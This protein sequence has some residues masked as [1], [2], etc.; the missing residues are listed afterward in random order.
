MEHS[1][2][3][4][5][6]ISKIKKYHPTNNFAQVEKAYKIALEAHGDQLR[7]SGEPYIIHPLS[8]AV[9]LA[10]LE[11]D[12]ESIIAGILH[13]VIEDTVFSFEDISNM[14]SEEIA[15]IVDGVT[16][17]DKIQYKSAEDLKDGT[18]DT[19]KL[20][21]K[22]ERYNQEVLAE[23]YRK[24]FLAMAKDIRVILIK[25][26]DRLH[27]MRTLKFMKPEKQKE[28]AQE[29]LDIYAPLAHRLGIS[30]IRYELEDLSFRYLYPDAYYDL[31]DK[32]K[33]KQSERLEYVNKI[34]DSVKQKLN[35]SG[36]EGAVEGRPK[37][38]FSIYK[39][40]VSQNKTLDQIYDLFAVRVIV[41]SI[42]DCYTVL[43]IVHEVYTPMPGRFKDYIAMPKSNVYQSLHTSLVGS[44]GEPFEVQIRT[45]EMHRRAE[46]GIAAH[47]R[48]KE[49]KSKND[50]G[51]KGG[52]QEVDPEEAKLVWLRQILEWQKELSDNSEFLNAIKSDLDIYKDQVYCFTPKGQLKILVTGATPIDFAYAIH[53]AIG[54][55]MIG[56][57][58]NGSI[59]TF[60]YEL[61]TGD[62]VEIITSQNSRGPGR[63]WLKIAKT[64]QARNKIKQW[65]Y[66]ENKEENILKG[67][68][69][70]ESHAKKKGVPF[71]ELCANN[72][73]SKV[74]DR[75]SFGDLNSLLAAIGHASVNEGQVI[76]RLY[77]L[78]QKENQQEIITP[79]QLITKNQPQ[80]SDHSA[81]GIIIHGIGG[82]AVRLSRCCS[83]VPGDEIVGFVTRGRG[84]SIHR[85]DCVNMI[86]LDEIERHR[87]I[88]AQWS[89]PEKTDQ[90]VAYR[91]EISIECSDKN[92]MFF[93]ISKILNEEKI[94]IKSITGRTVD[95]TA[96]INVAIEI[97]DRTQLDRVLKN[98]LKINGVY[99]IHRAFI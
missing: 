83:P 86:H 12:L 38:F 45:F 77:E 16:K 80:H 85:T 24:M 44:T 67:K 34:V 99:D 74:L 2:I 95:Q 35:E 37:H 39:K 21:Q 79:E 58:V 98:L 91:A 5:D 25:M 3:F 64:S 75:F 92:G 17:L 63:D 66:K 89:K 8:V 30:K 9:I 1:E 10:E 4:S 26:A 73:L 28:K 50:K 62:I 23:N 59:A 65:F 7:K 6:L 56:A 93:E 43:G 76:N 42:K 54:N 57:R 51:P 69:L 53:T 20:S 19:H 22:E 52:Q 31:A 84:V 82:V 88:D 15:Q 46:Y 78:Y 97:T 18:K 68:E 47:W 33:Q 11:L 61:K 40:M 29:T 94:S 14:F 41:E 27:N 70:V 48:Y 36:I 87:L 32:I 60:E 49:G 55:K 96:I 71:N 81:G 90:A 72:R 13:D